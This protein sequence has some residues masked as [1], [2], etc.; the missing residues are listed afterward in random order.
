MVAVR[1]HLDE[2]TV[3]W[4]LSGDAAVQFQTWRDLLGRERPELQRRIASDG[5]AAAIL[6]AHSSPGWGRGFYEPKWTCPHYA[7]LELRDLAV[8]RDHPV[9]VGEVAVAL[10]RHKGD[11]G[12]FNPT[13]SVKQ[14]D[15]CMSGMFL[16]FG[17]YFRADAAG[18]RSIVD[19]MLGQR[20]DD[21]GFNCRANRSGAVVSSVHSTT[22]V[23]EGL[24]EY[25]NRGYAYRAADVRDAIGTATAS[26]LA[27]QLYQ[28]RSDG[29]PIRAEFTRLHH[30]ARWHFDVLRGLDVLRGAGTTYDDRLDAA[31]EVLFRRRR[32]DGRWAAASQY[33]GQVHLSYPRAGRP[34]RWVT[35]RALRVLA[36]ANP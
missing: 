2:E 27:R 36:W 11:D 32:P 30:P 28:R 15:V 22:S 16:A 33:P 7:L 19:F 31:V 5:A 13:D 21:G 9:C 6:A 26:L 23:I 12:G 8:P 24:A 18:L 29:E 3:A 17:C 1:R 10:A 25:L 20:M 34:S 14:S 35:L 4:L